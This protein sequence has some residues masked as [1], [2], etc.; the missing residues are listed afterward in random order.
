MDP[1][2]PMRAAT[3]AGPGAV[4]ARAGAAGFALPAG[5]P[6]AAVPALPLAGLLAVQE[7]AV[8]PP[9]DRAARRRGRALLAEL[10]GLQRDLLGA[11]VDGARLVRLRALAAEVPPAAT[12]PALAAALAAIVL[13]AR[14]ELARFGDD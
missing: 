13:R 11:G 1:I 3:I 5:R 8:E 12:D 9:A 6:P 2:G 14:V 4:P 7:E 10:S